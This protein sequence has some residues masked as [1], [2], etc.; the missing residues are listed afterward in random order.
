MKINRIP[1]NVV[2]RVSF[3]KMG[4]GGGETIL[5][6]NMGGGGSVYDSAPSRGGMGAS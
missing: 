1:I 3:R 4:K 2:L 6:K 5:T